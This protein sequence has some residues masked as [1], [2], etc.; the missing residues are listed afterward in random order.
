MQFRGDNDDL[1]FVHHDVRKLIG[2]INI[3]R[4]MGN[5]FIR[6]MNEINKLK[7]VGTYTYTTTI[8]IIEGIDREDMDPI[9]WTN[10]KVSF[11]EWVAALNCLF[12][13][14]G[15]EHGIRAVLTLTNKAIHLKYDQGMSTGDIIFGEFCF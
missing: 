1:I 9:N 8:P 15:G 10:A 14:Y 11:R 13:K 2:N 12:H 6:R 7:L 4:L 3:H 5:N